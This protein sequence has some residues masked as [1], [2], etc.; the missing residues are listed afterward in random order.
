[1]AEAVVSFA[2]ET[3]AGLLIEEAK[4]LVGVTDQAEQLQ[5]ELRWMKWFLRD[6]DARQDDKERIRE[7]VSEVKDIAYQAGDL[8][9]S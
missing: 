9:E 2:I 3:I 7:W 8:L 5:S 4:F 6:A 1:M